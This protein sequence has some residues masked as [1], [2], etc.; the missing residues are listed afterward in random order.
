MAVFTKII[1]TKTPLDKIRQYLHGSGIDMIKLGDSAGIGQI[2]V[3][4]VC[5]D[6]SPS[7]PRTMK[8]IDNLLMKLE[9]VKEVKEHRNDPSSTTK[10]N[11]S[12]QIS[13]DKD[14]PQSG[15]IQGDSKE[16]ER[17]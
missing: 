13:T 17:G 15:M 16:I 6:S 5:S 1:R 14:T 11:M 4:L 12:L 7:N 10:A 2:T 3:K 8:D 9:G